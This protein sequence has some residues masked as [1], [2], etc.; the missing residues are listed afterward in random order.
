MRLNNNPKLHLTVV[1]TMVAFSLVIAM[2]TK[3]NSNNPGK[4]TVG[5]HPETHIQPPVAAANVPYTL[6]TVNTVSPTLLEYASGSAV[7]LPDSAFVDEE[8]NPVTGEVIIHFR[9]FNDAIDIYLS[10]IPMEYTM[11]GEKYYFESA[12]MCEIYAEQEGQKVH[13][14][15]GKKIEIMQVSYTTSNIF[16]LYEFDSEKGE[17][18]EKGKDNPVY[19]DSEQMMTEAAF[20][21]RPELSKQKRYKPVEPVKAD[22]EKLNFSI[23]VVEEDFPELSGFKDFL[24]EIVETMKFH[25]PGENKIIWE[26]IKIS[27]DEEPGNYIATFS[28]PNEDKKV[29]FTVRPVYKDEAYDNA[30]ELYQQ[31]LEE[32]NSYT[33]ETNILADAGIP[34]P[35][36]ARIDSINKAVESR[37]SV[38]SN[39]ENSTSSDVE[40]SPGDVL[41]KELW[42][43]RAAVVFSDYIPYD[44]KEVLI[45]NVAEPAQIMENKAMIEQLYALHLDE[46]GKASRDQTVRNNIFRTFQVDNFGIFNVDVPG[47]LPGD[48]V[49]MANFRSGD[50]KLEEVINLVDK[51]RRAVYYYPK[52]NHPNFRYNPNA[53]NLIWTLRDNS[54][55]Y[56]NDF[57]AI[58]PD[59]DER[60]FTFH[61]KKVD[62]PLDSYEKARE[63]LKSL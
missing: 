28:Q 57:K 63:I 5:V 38:Q 40:Q 11:N 7:L 6:D 34:V 20:L 10:G 4:A 49:I 27:R 23:S 3:T 47:D 1:I 15:P 29:S 60:E 42:E 33:E 62:K 19:M 26:D 25:Q 37:N 55:Y 18:I 14:R 16:N 46:R 9:E 41:I 58:S 13:L 21:S 53:D 32:Y 45:Y 43:K 30:K 59:L 54:L 56:F 22:P 12:A 2:L 52:S 61:M 48:R 51:S 44:Q 50:K 8:G 24:F 36:K 31:K 17:W 35:L 39:A